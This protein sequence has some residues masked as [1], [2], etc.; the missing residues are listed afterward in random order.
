MNYEQL[1]RNLA[2]RYGVQASSI[3]SGMTVKNPVV[4]EAMAFIKAKFAEDQCAEVYESIINN[5][6]PTSTVKFPTVT[7]VRECTVSIKLHEKTGRITEIAISVSRDWH[8]K[9]IYKNIMY[10]RE[11]AKLGLATAVEI[12]MVS[13]WEELCYRYEVLLNDRATDH[14]IEAYCLKVKES[15][16]KGEPLDPIKRNAEKV[17][18][19]ESK[20]IKIDF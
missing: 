10:Y 12:E 3:V 8:P 5:F 6:V 18:N 16:L 1:E 14:H 19:L 4:Q 17:K 2:T 15:I 13:I 11:K 20:V 9:R 7:D